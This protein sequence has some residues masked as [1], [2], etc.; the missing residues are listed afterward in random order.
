MYKSDFCEVSYSE[1]L[2]SVLVTWKKFCRG[3]DYR[4]PLRCALSVMKD[5]IGCNYCADTR[6]GFENEEADTQWVFDYFLPQA[7]KREYR[8]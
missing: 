7:D 1:E 6:N 8:R 5:C 2:N 4:D 3:D